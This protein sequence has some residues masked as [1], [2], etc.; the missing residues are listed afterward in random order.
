MFNKRLR[1]AWWMG[2]LLMAGSTFGNP[3]PFPA[4]QAEEAKPLFRPAGVRYQVKDPA[5]SVAFYTRYLGFKETGPFGGPK[6]DLPAGAPFASVA[7]GSLILWLSG[8]GSSGSRPLPDGRA[9]TPGGWNRIALAVDDLETRVAELKK[10]GL[11]FRNEIV[12]GPGGKQIQLEDPDGN[13]IELFEP[14]R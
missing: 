3:R 14:G 11:H 9:Q 2:A 12:A 8:P 6:M 1:A 4:A 5:R 13:P 7:N 10:G